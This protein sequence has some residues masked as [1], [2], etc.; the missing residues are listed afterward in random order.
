MKETTYLE[1]KSG[2]DTVLKRGHFFCI[3]SILMTETAH[4]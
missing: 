4:C 2:L 3:Q 1:N